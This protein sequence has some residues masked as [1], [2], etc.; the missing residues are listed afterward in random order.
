MSNPGYALVNSSIS[1]EIQYKP[2]G[3]AEFKT[4]RAV[5]NYKEL[6]SGNLKRSDNSPMIYSVEVVLC[7]AD[8]PVVTKEDDFI[9]DDISGRERTYRVREILANA[10][11]MW[12]VGA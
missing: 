12:R 8:I 9:C 5:V 6:Q 4:I 1:T 2:K 11:D 7:K 3:D 10:F